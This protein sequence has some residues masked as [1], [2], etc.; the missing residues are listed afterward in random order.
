MATNTRTKTFGVASVVVGIAAATV[1][2]RSAL[3]APAK[4][5]PADGATTTEHRCK[6]GEKDCKG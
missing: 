5:A 4:A 3:G 6:P 1:V 2:I